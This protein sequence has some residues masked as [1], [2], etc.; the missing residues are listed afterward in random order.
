MNKTASIAIIA[1]VVGGLIGFALNGNEKNTMPE[2][3]HEMADGTMMADQMMGSDSMEQMMH[4]MNAELIGKTGADFDR[5]F[6]EQMVIHH[7]GAV[8][9]AELALTNAESQELK[10]LATAIITA[11]NSEIELMNSWRAAW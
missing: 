7:E 2:G 11:Q 10:D 8:A 6:V 3:M 9:M 1:L 4:D 5:A